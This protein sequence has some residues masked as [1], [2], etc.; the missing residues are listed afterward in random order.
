MV[1]VGRST[2]Q[3]C[4]TLAKCRFSVP[5]P[6][7][8]VLKIALKV[9]ESATLVSPWLKGLK[10]FAY[11]SYW[12]NAPFP[13][14]L[15][16][17]V[18]GVTFLI[19]T[20]LGLHEIWRDQSDEAILHRIETTDS[21]LFAS[22]EL[23]KLSERGIHQVWKDEKYFTKLHAVSIV[24]LFKGDLDV[25]GKEEIFLR[26]TSRQKQ[27]L[28]KESFSSLLDFLTRPYSRSL[29]E[30]PQPLL[31][32]LF[33][34]IGIPPLSFYA[35]SNSNILKD[36]DFSKVQFIE[37]IG[38]KRFKFP[39]Q[40]VITRIKKG[41][42][43]NNGLNEFD[44]V[45]RAFK[46]VHA[47]LSHEQVQAFYQQMRQS[48]LFHYGE[49]LKNHMEEP[50]KSQIL[51]DICN[52]LEK[53]ESTEKREDR[54]R[55]YLAEKTEAASREYFRKTPFNEEF[56]NFLV[57]KEEWFTEEFVDANESLSYSPAQIACLAV[58][59][60]I[61]DGKKICP[62]PN[63]QENLDRVKEMFDDLSTENKK[64]LLKR[65]FVQDNDLSDESTHSCWKLIHELASELERGSLMVEK[66]NR[67]YRAL[68]MGYEESDTS[69]NHFNEATRK[70]WMEI[71]S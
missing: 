48:D 51:E 3:A 23:T 35:L 21:P 39:P 58:L 18:L 12:K 67:D 59:L 5:E 40:D 2:P 25:S 42:M 24:D 37:K 70:V 17:C 9:L 45:V 54:Y 34:K 32:H 26:L 50:I 46:K 57:E 16:K 47:L 29:S 30:L 63:R 64:H 62:D 19:P 43:D 49:I 22:Y 68:L 4:P 60:E 71:F 53:M 27:E 28:Y 13:Y 52:I 10:K 69:V 65:L 31:E 41:L 55:D 15:T 61:H 1:T 7:I 14:E 56:K 6:A 66:K 11:I 8:K 33:Y 38:K 36:L 44:G 20:L